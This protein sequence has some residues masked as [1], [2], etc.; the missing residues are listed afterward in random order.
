MSASHQ[1]EEACMSE[2]R[3]GWVGHESEAQALAAKYAFIADDNYADRAELSDQMIGEKRKTLT[4]QVEEVEKMKKRRRKLVE[5]PEQQEAAVGVSTIANDM[6]GGIQPEKRKKKKKKKKKRSKNKCNGLTVLGGS[7]LL[8]KRAGA[9][10]SSL[11]GKSVGWLKKLMKGKQ[12]QQHAVTVALPP[13]ASEAHQL[14]SQA[15]QVDDVEKKRK[16]LYKQHEAAVGTPAVATNVGGGEQPETGQTKKNKKKKKKC[17]G[18]WKA[19]AS[20]ELPSGP[21]LLSQHAGVDQSSLLSSHVAFLKQQKTGKQMQRHAGT[22]DL[23]SVA[24]EAH[25]GIATPGAH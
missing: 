21:V 12:M 25:Q 22:K 4:V 10:R 20:L 6:A 18:C 9:A 8:F 17:N 1:G 24:S 2:E 11:P 23:S 13:V 3:H 7:A 14:A 19:E 16:K 15:H 5:E